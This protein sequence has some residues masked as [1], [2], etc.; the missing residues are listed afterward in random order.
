MSVNILSE[1][2]ITLQQAACRVP[3][4]RGRKSVSFSCVL[5]W[6]KKGIPG[7]DGD[8]VRFEAIRMGGKWLTT[9]EALERWSMRLTPRLDGAPI[10][11]P[12]TLNQRERAAAKA[13]ARLEKI[14]I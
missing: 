11:T 12:R 2:L 7:P 1:N 8:R 10:P 3:S 6:I 9:V 13:V 14:G 5:R 4:S